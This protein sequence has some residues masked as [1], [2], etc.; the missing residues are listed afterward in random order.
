MDSDLCKIDDSI[1]CIYCQSQTTV[2]ANNNLEI[3]PNVRKYTF[4]NR[5]FTAII[6]TINYIKAHSYKGRDKACKFLPIHRK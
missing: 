4:T 6:R 5:F 1:S 3:P 2:F